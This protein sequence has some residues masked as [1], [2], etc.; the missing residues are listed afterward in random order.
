M[1]HQPGETI[2]IA[3][4]N[5]IITQVN[6]IFGTGTGTSGYGGNSTNVSV[7][8][9]PVAVIGT[10]IDNQE[11][12]DLRNAQAD[13]ATHQGV[14]LPAGLPPIA[15][16]E[17]ADSIQAFDDQ[18]APDNPAGEI[19]SAANLAAIVANKDLVASVAITPAG[20][21]TH[22]RGTGWSSFIQHEFTVDFGS[23]DAARHYFNTGGQIRISASRSGGSATT[24]NTEWTNL[25]S[26]NSPFVFDQTA[27]FLLTS[28]F[29]VFPFPNPETAREVCSAGL[30]SLNCWTILSR[31]DDGTG[32]NNGNGS[33]LR[34][35]SN[36][37]DGHTNVFS[38]TVDGTFTSTIQEQKAT[39][40][41]IRP[42][43]TFTTITA[44][45]AGS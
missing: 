36:F 17:T 39:T 35:Q 31:R 40:E 15:D 42:S 18:T 32:P 3:S 22:N 29:P 27:Y 24:Q 5:D 43:P 14:A 10:A 21:I 9:L 2:T 33:I 28:S 25:L 4:Y 19:D 45:T 34:F 12:L 26:A 37:L 6:T 23:A 8:D 16:L 7:T 11:W 20:A 38:D 30:Y 13:I 44:L 41:F 1:T